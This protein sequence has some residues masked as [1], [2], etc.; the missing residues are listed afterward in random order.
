[1]RRIILSSPL[2]RFIYIPDGNN[3]N[4]NEADGISRK[5]GDANEVHALICRGSSCEFR[6]AEAAALAQALRISID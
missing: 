1:M 4:E 2:P 3:I 6:I 5:D